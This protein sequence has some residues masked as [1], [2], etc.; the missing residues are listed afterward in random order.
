MNSFETISSF[1][2]YQGRASLKKKKKNRA[3]LAQFCLCDACCNV[4]QQFSTG[5]PREFLKYIL[6][7]YLVRGTDLFP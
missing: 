2:S 3:T 1:G 6:P 5:V 4:D 7:D